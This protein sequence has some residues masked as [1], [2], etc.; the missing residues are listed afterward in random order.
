[1]RNV[2]PLVRNLGI[3]ALIALVIVVLNQ[4]TALATATNLLRVAFFI[5]IAVV[6]YFYWRDFGRREIGLWSARAQRVF[7]AAAV[8]LVVDIGWWVVHHPQGRDALISIVVA[9][10][11]GYVGVRAWREQRRYS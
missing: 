11:C 1:M 9:V 6:V 4:E 3:L 8:L 7:Y 5:A 2:S 10:I